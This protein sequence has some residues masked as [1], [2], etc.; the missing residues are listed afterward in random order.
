MSTKEASNTR[1]LRKRSKE[2]Y[3]ES[4][5]DDECEDEM[6]EVK[7]KKLTKTSIRRGDL[8]SYSADSKEILG[9][10]SYERAIALFE[11]TDPALSD[12]I[13]SCGY[14]HT[15]FEIKLSAYQT[16]VKL[17]ISE[18]L[19]TSAAGSITKRFIE[20]FLK[21]G[22]SIESY[23]QFKAHT[24]F[25][26][27]ESVKEASQ[28]EL[29]STGISF[30]KAGYLIAMSK[31]FSAKNY[32]LNDD[33]KLKNMTNKEIAELLLDLKGVGPWSVDMFLLLHMKRPDVF[34]IRD[35]GI[36]A[37][38]STLEQNTLSKNRKKL[39]HLSV[40]EMEKHAE[41]WKP[42]RSVASWYLMELSTPGRVKE[43]LKIS[44]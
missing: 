38:L 10:S 36:R 15:L 3:I 31:K 37:G 16:L 5:N 44:E 20:L 9:S 26:K 25:P 7:K 24:L 43:Y 22:E 23:D 19:S 17:L 40:E 34:P 14:P 18:K 29:R 13:K 6:P 42:Y 21:N 11:K 33:K 39:N 41:K 32:S 1:S 8:E 4:N 2:E 27:P 30:R 12:F 28:E 35:E